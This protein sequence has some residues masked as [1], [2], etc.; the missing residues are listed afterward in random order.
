[1]LGDVVRRLGRLDEAE[2][3]LRGAVA[4]QATT[5]GEPHPDLTRSLGFLGR[6]LADGGRWDEAHETHER[7]LLFARTAL[8]ADHPIRSEVVD[9]LMVYYRARGRP[10]DAERI[11]R[12]AAGVATPG[13][14]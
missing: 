13:R 14:P 5:L 11:R 6:V 7:G 12:E 2:M 10:Q 8:A 9:G 4:A 3:L 1:M